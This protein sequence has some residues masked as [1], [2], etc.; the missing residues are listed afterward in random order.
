MFMCTLLQ[1][2]ENHLY[3]RDS[4]YFMGPCIPAA[5]TLFPSSK[6]L[7]ENVKSTHP[8]SGESGSLGS[9]PR[10]KLD[11]WCQDWILDAGGSKH[12]GG[13]GRSG[14]PEAVCWSVGFVPGGLAEGGERMWEQ[15]HLGSPVSSLLLP[16]PSTAPLPAPGL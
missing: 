11:P 4:V 7:R 5:A 10:G 8:T 2:R 13:W 3:S 6:F 1:R 15:V 16:A 14:G 12:P 9:V